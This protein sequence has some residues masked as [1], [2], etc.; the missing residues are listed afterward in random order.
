MKTLLSFLACLTA[1][2]GFTLT[3]LAQGVGETP[4]RKAETLRISITGIPL[5]DQSSMAAQSFIIS[6][7]GTVNLTHLKTPLRAVG[8]T[9]SQLAQSIESAYKAARIYTKPT[10]NVQRMVGPDTQQIVT[11][12][13]NVKQPGICVF[14]PGMKLNE[15][16][17]ER[18][19]FDEFAKKNR[20]RVMRR[21]GVKE[22]D[23]RN[24]SKNQENNVLL[25]PG[26]EIIV[27]QGF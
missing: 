1:W 10:V 16:I 27:P 25:E 21:G 4:L 2:C 18:G 17:T 19:G 8:F 26:D 23:L 20:V 15:A 9:P 14:R 13:G 5:S 22:Y 12:G 24:L 11:V 7:D 3:V 6:N